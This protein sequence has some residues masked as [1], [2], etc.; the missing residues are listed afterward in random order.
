LEAHLRALLFPSLICLL[1][2]LPLAGQA[3]SSPANENYFLRELRASSQPYLMLFPDRPNSFLAA[4]AAK[5][6]K[7]E[8]IVDLGLRLTLHD[9]SMA[10]IRETTN[11]LRRRF[12]IGQNTQ[13]AVV[14]SNEQVL[15]SGLGLPSAPEM[16]QMLAAKGVQSPIR[17]LREFLKKRPDHLDARSELLRLQQTNAGRR[18][19]EALGLEV[20]ERPGG[21]SLSALPATGSGGP[22]PMR[23]EMRVPREG[24]NRGNNSV[25]QVI[26]SSFDRPKSSPIPAD[27]LLDAETDLQIWSGYAESLDRLMSGDGWIAVGLNFDN[28]VV[29]YESCSPLVKGLY[30]RKIGQVED[31]LE[32]A[33]T[34]ANFWS[35]WIRMADTIGG[36]SIQTVV[37]R[38][39]QQPDSTFSSW[40]V[41]VR[42]RL[43]EEARAT[44]KWDF[45]TDSLWAEYESTI[46]TSMAV[47]AMSLDQNPNSSA[48]DISKMVN[49]MMWD[50]QWGSLYEPLLEALIK[51]NDGRAD[52]IMN[53]LHDRQQKGQWSESQMFKGIGL[54][55]LCG[56]PDI[57][58]RWS[59]AYLT[60]NQ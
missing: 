59:A 3:L 24:S 30:R 57:A 4:D 27:K 51:M 12:G 38:L 16:A 47:S 43:L 35:V 22:T 60:E 7:E 46:R 5:L 19:R 21:P 54:A 13:W 40:P 39:A 56:R 6:L 10:L 32:I 48:M 8:E 2:C 17:S 52:A 11:A 15:A 14:D 28:S 53:A 26:S 36:R 29:L 58:Q 18:T 1:I 55:N 42:E 49:E 20:E 45:I 37:G 25:P 41:E 50:Q 44:N 23:F 34:N 9:N 31:A 33:P